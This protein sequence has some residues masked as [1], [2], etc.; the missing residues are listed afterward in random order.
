MELVLKGQYK[1]LKY[2]EK[3]LSKFK[4]AYYIR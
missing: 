1:A 4:G 3:M 2:W